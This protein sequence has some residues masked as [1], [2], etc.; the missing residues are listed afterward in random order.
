VWI[1][2]TL[3]MGELSNAKE[4]VPEVHIYSPERSDAVMDALSAIMESVQYEP[5]EY[6]RVFPCVRDENSE[7]ACTHLLACYPE[8]EGEGF[9]EVSVEGKEVQFMRLVP[10]TNA[11][12]RFLEQ[13]GY[14]ALENRLESPD[15]VLYRWNRDS[16]V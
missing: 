10:I 16:V 9:P 7:G 12:V 3:G 15:G 4:R 5:L 8:A 11:E 1:D 14:D 2:A 13:N 6:G